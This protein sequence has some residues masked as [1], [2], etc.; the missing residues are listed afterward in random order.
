M[1]HQ[2]QQLRWLNTPG[3]VKYTLAFE[4]DMNLRHIVTSLLEETGPHEDVPSIKN[5]ETRRGPLDKLMGLRQRPISTPGVDKTIPL[6]EVREI[7]AAH[8]VQQVTQGYML[9]LQRSCLEQADPIYISPDVTDMIDY[10][11]ET[12]EPEPVLPTDPFTFCGFAWLPRPLKLDDHPTHEGEWV[13]WVRAISWIPVFDE[14]DSDRGCFWITFYVSADDDLTL[15]GGRKVDTRESFGPLAELTC[16][17]SFQWTWGTNPWPEF[18]GEARVRAKAQVALVQ[19]MWRLGSQVVATKQRLPRPRRRE[20]KR[21]NV[22]IE[23]VTV[24]TLRREGDRH[25]DEE[26]ESPEW[27]HKWL[28]RGHWRNQWY[29]SLK[30]HRQVWIAPYVKGPE[31][32]PLKLTKRVFEF[33]R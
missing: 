5:L 8:N 7:A 30:E 25:Y 18:E 1:H 9:L 31:H 11:R 4:D 22:K 21:H 10:A 6:S 24:I 16:V 2:V 26:G 20:A 3:G 17:H 23:D 33:T 15:E 28:V 14:R 19:T 12:F 13:V 29:P 27:K 32:L